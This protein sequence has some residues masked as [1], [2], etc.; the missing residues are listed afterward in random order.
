MTIRDGGYYPVV[1]FSNTKIR[2]GDDLTVSISGG[3]PNSKFKW[4]ATIITPENPTGALVNDF[5]VR[6]NEFGELIS[7][8]KKENYTSA[9][10]WVCDINFLG[11]GVNQ[12]RT[13]EIVDGVYFPVI[14]VASGLVRFG[15][16]FTVK[17]ANGR[18]NAVVP[19]KTRLNG[20]LI[21]STSVSLDSSGNF[22]VTFTQAN[23][24]AAGQWSIE[25]DFGSDGGVKTQNISIVEGIYSPIVTGPPGNVVFGSDFT[26]S[27][28]SGKPLS[29]FTS[30]A[31]L[32]DIFISKSSGTL[33][34][35]GALEVV[36]KEINYTSPGRWTL[37][38]DFFENGGVKTI[39][40][41]I[42]SEF[43]PVILVPQAPVLFGNN[44]PV[45][46]VGGRPRSSVTAESSLNGNFISRNTFNLDN[47]GGYSVSFEKVNYGSP[48]NW[49]IS[50]DFG[51]DGG[52]KSKNIAIV[53]EYKPVVTV[54][55]DVVKFGDPFT[56]TIQSGKENSP[57][58]VKIWHNTV[59][60]NDVDIV[61]DPQGGWSITFEKINYTVAGTWEIECDFGVNGGKILKVVTISHESSLRVYRPTITAPTITVPFGNSFDIVINGG[62]PG[63]VVAFRIKLTNANNPNGNL[64]N[65]G[66]FPLDLYGSWNA[67]FVE[68]NYVEEI[69]RASCRERV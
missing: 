48:G 19:T 18:P 69:G 20:T 63:A 46:I 4:K 65:V 49:S 36:F 16:S 33:D 62:K 39:A 2:Y 45:S 9:G 23:Y 44:I 29:K 66:N 43:N 55:L 6:L 47:Q 15:D 28:T 40:V 59:I 54:P 52:I 21:N 14:E 60:L 1:I 3:K 41:N 10:T 13:V 58:H 7:T 38:T 31:K 37:E 51:L 50:V 42:T 61:L 5:E 57:V 34:E 11:N 30:V 67:T 35:F 32:D 53:S 25:C 64:I 24:L 68:D 17:L 22:I 12:T 56:V 26:V 27:V 8:F